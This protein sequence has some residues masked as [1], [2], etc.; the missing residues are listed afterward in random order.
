[1]LDSPPQL[2]AAAGIYLRL[3]LDL[4]QQ[5]HWHCACLHHLHRTFSSASYAHL[6]ILLLS[7]VG[8]L[9]PLGRA[10]TFI[11]FY[12]PGGGGIRSLVTT[13][14]YTSRVESKLASAMDTCLGMGV[15]ATVWSACLHAFPLGCLLLPC[16]EILQ[17][18]GWDGGCKC[19]SLQHLPISLLSFVVF[20]ISPLPFAIFPLF[21]RMTCLLVSYFYS[22]FPCFLTSN[23]HPFPFH[24]SLDMVWW[25]NYITLLLFAT[26]LNSRINSWESWFIFN[27]Q[28]NKQ[29]GMRA[30]Y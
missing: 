8:T 29:S 16:V 2:A 6:D 19:Y 17:Q 22:T 13:I 26:M 12:K 3:P 4:G 18:D 20:S 15:L 30:N 23:Q 11:L 5:C 27:L 21:F 10:S 28:R 1:M 24:F 25:S 9:E 14:P 7:A